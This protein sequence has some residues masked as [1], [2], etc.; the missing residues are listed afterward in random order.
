MYR[1]GLGF[2]DD[3]PLS[4]LGTDPRSRSLF[5]GGLL[6]AAVLLAG[7]SWFAK[8][9]CS[10]PTSFLAASLIGL[11]GQVVA[12]VV[13][14]SGTGAA[15]AVHTTAGLVLGISLPVL[16]WRFAAGQP[17]GRGRQESYG[18][19]WLEAA[20]CAVGVELSRSM[21]APIAEVLPACAFHLWIAVVTVRSR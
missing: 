6:C 13:P 16:M 10:T 8:E 14:I 19:F 21:R 18:L 1:T 20:A 4:Y 7:F 17:P 15:Y 9:R 12:A 5:R 3:E 2:F 11:G